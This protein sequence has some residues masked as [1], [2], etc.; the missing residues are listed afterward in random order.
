MAACDCCKFGFEPSAILSSKCGLDSPEDLCVYL[1]IF[2]KEF[3]TGA[4]LSETLHE[5]TVV[6]FEACVGYTLATC[7]RAPDTH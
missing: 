6:R 7:L 1:M 4:W 3:P 2:L 5:R